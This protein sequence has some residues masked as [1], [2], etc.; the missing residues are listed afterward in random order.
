M[1][2]REF[3]LAVAALASLGFAACGSQV[4]SATLTPD[5][6]GIPCDAD[7]LCPGTMS[8]DNTAGLCQPGTSIPSCASGLTLCSGGC[9]DTSKSGQVQSSR[10]SE[11]ALPG[12]ALFESQEELDSYLRNMQRKHHA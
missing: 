4:P 10:S 12:F 8:C 2:S 6:A 3:G 1:T 11:R 9:S 7:G 5:A